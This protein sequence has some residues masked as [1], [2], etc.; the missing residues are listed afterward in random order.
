MLD[1]IAPTADLHHA[2]LKFRDEWGGEEL[3]G[4]GLSARYDVVSAEGFA[5]WVAYLRRQGDLSIPVEPGRVHADYWWI[6]ERQPGGDTAILGAIT[7]RH[8]LND[9]LTEAGGHIGYGVRPSARRRGV[10]SWALGEVLRRAKTRRLDRVLITCD[11]TNVGS[12]RTIERNGGIL[13]DIRN[14]PLG[15][16]RRYWISL[17]G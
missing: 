15:R 17:N 2:W 11:D 8:E 12:A 14:T 7:L 16:T 5:G 10:A 13:E 1:L 4:A 3:H 6:A 9:F